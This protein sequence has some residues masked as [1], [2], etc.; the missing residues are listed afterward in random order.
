MQDKRSPDGGQWAPWATR[1][2]A[3]RGRKGNAAQGLLW[4]SGTLLASIQMQA[5]DGLV[6]IG[7]DTAYAQYL[8]GGTG[9]MPAREFLG[10]TERDTKAAERMVL[11]YIEGAPGVNVA[12]IAA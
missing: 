4:D 12:S 3:S 7:T 6:S 2:A 9:N 1:T 8:Q 10:W 11:D 5:R